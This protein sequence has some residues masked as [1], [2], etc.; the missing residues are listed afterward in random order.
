MRNILLIED[1]AD[2][3]EN[4]EL[5]LGDDD[6]NVISVACPHDAFHYLASDQFDAVICDLHLPFILNEKITHYPYSIEVGIQTINELRNILPGTPIIGISASMESDLPRI[7]EEKNFVPLLQKPFSRS[8]LLNA[9]S[10][11]EFKTASIE[12]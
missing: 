3:R 4:I 10:R 7:E 8:T 1:S 11:A 5:L 9:I 2:Y 6:Y 12:Q